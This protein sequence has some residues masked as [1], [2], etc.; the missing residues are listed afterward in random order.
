M[1]VAGDIKERE[2]VFLYETEKNKN[3]KQKQNLVLGTE[4]SIEFEE[5]IKWS[6][7]ERQIGLVGS[8][9]QGFLPQIQG[10]PKNKSFGDDL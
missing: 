10:Q 5:R 9:S 2:R 3:K 7:E 8:L 1:Q 6:L 4:Q